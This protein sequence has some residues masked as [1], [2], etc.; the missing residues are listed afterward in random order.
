MASVWEFILYPMIEGRYLPGKRFF[1]PAF[2][3]SAKDRDLKV[4]IPLAPRFFPLALFF[5]ASFIFFHCSLDIPL[6]MY[7]MVMPLVFWTAET[8]D[9]EKEEEVEKAETWETARARV[10]VLAKD[11]MVVFLLFQ[12]CETD[13]KADDRNSTVLYNQS[14]SGDLDRFRE[15]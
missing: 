9:P 8:D 7:S 11:F 13:M 4:V 6:G 12:D 2:C 5:S 3:Q 15:L 10:M 1:P 14:S